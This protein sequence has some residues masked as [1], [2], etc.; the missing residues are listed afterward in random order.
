MIKKYFISILIIFSL[1]LTVFAKSKDSGKNVTE[2]GEKKSYVG[3]V[4]ASSKEI[5][6]KKGMI[7]FRVKPNLGSFNISVTNNKEKMIPVLSTVDEFTSTLFYLK[8]P[9]KI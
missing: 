7:Q 9:K 3:W 4:D 1:C 5:S 6:Y 8:T 2:D